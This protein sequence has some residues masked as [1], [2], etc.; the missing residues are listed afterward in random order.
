MQ[1]GSEFFKL[2]LGALKASKNQIRLPKSKFPFSGIKSEPLLFYNRCCLSCRFALSFNPDSLPS[3]SL[4]EISVDS[5]LWLMN[6]GHPNDHTFKTENHP[7]TKKLWLFKNHASAVSFWHFG[8]ESA[9]VLLLHWLPNPFR[10]P[11]LMQPWYNS[12]PSLRYSF[13]A[14]FCLLSFKTSPPPPPA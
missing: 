9:S 8:N 13:Y 10:I 3:C 6:R 1:R 2:N 4:H 5:D 12:R 11:I 14:H 7:P